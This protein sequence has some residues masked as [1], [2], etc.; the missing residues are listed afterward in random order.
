MKITGQRTV[1]ARMRIGPNSVE[2][3]L[4]CGHTL[5]RAN[6]EAVRPTAICGECRSLKPTRT[7]RLRRMYET[8]RAMQRQSEEKS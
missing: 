3:K 1:L 8:K 6:R 4:S 7:E 5:V 2:C